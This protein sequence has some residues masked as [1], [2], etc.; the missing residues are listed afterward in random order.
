MFTT[1]FQLPL[2]WRP[3][4][5][6]VRAQVCRRCSSFARGGGPTSAPCLAIPNH[7]RRCSGGWVSIPGVPDDS[8]AA[9]RVL[10]YPPL[11]WRRISKVVGEVMET[12]VEELQKAERIPTPVRQDSRE[13]TVAATLL[14]AGYCSA[15]WEFW[16]RGGEGRE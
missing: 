14:A 8:H 3:P 12:L 1:Y 16:R 11:G 6:S 7:G 13:I 5:C 10:P 2:Q 15:F 9:T 4:L